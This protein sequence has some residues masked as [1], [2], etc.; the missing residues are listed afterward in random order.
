MHV[1]FTFFDQPS[2][3]RLLASGQSHLIKHLLSMASRTA[4]SSLRRAVHSSAS[5]SAPPS[6]YLECRHVACFFS[7]RL[8]DGP[9]ASPYSEATQQLEGLAVQVMWVIS[10]LFKYAVSCCMEADPFLRLH[11]LRLP[12]QSYYLA[13]AASRE[14]SMSLSFLFYQRW[15]IEHTWLMQHSY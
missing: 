13:Q 11:S 2:S 14:L 5:C 4:G 7:D 9:Q 15:A 1:G 6:A 8:F 3:F 10:P 12:L